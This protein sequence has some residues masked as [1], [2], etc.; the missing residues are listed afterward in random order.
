MMGT[1]FL[2][3]KAIFTALI[4]LPPEAR[5]AYLQAQ[6]DIDDA[7]RRRIEELLAADADVQAVSTRRA[8]GS[9]TAQVRDADWSGRLIGAYRVERT[10]GH[11]GMGSVFLAHR[12]DGSLEQMVAIKVVRPALVSAS[13]LARFRLERQVLALLQHPNVPKMLDAGELPG[14]QPYVV[15]EY[16]AGE[17]ID[18]YAR[19]QRLDVR[20]RLSLFLAVCDAVGYA[21]RNLV[22]HRDL[23]PA[24]VLVDASGRPQLLDFGIAKPLQRQFGAVDAIETGLVDRF[25]SPVYAA[26]EQLRGT[27][28]TT[29]CDVYALG[30]LLYELLAGAPPFAQDGISPG[31]LEQR[32]LDVDPP[33]PSVRA[34]QQDERATGLVVDRDLD[35]IVLR[36]L[37]KEPADRYGSVDALAEDLQRY[38][39]GLPVQARQGNGWYR[40]SRFV[41]RHRVALAAAVLVA[42]TATVGGMLLWRQQHATQTE[43]LR[44]DNMAGLITNALASL[45]PASRATRDMSAREMFERI[46]VQTETDPSLD[47]TSRSRVLGVVAGILLKLGQIPSANRILEQ[48]DASRLDTGTRNDIANLRVHAFVAQSRFDDARRLVEN[49][50]ATVSADD[51]E[52]KAELMLLSAMVDFRQGRRIPLVWDK[53]AAV[54]VDRLSPDEIDQWRSLRAS[55][56]FHLD[57][58][59]DAI[60]EA[61]LLIE[62]QRKRLGPDSPAVFESLRRRAMLENLRG[63]FA[64]SARISEELLQH[65]EKYYGRNSSHYARALNGAALA[66]GGSGDRAQAVNYLHQALAIAVDQHGA[67]SEE[68]W[69]HHVNLGSQYEDDNK[70]DEA[71]THYEKAHEIAQR[72]WLPDDTNLLLSRTAY[73]TLLALE[74]KSTELEPVVQAARRDIAAHPQLDAP[75]FI[76]LLEAGYAL[77]AFRR[78]RSAAKRQS[79]IDALSKADAVCLENPDVKKAYL[80]IQ[81]KARGLLELG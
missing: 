44:A 34:R 80:K 43:R 55:A 70:P 63:N 7:T 53:L 56:L 62:E 73:A 50:M 9:D 15:M 27:A 14:G 4:E 45:D 26:P 77:D 41:V 33:P 66:A 18:R 13:T 32:I 51:L 3:I 65:S 21:H 67:N 39:Q 75:D 49:E 69:I 57:R 74:E 46:A 23:K 35:S 47:A 59:D 29:A 28:I 36:C 58:H 64:E 1:S 81:A 76:A 78:D 61:T 6:Q 11:G 25:L 68:A 24:N 17:P 60:A 20:Q 72:L 16:I 5:S 22:V 79:L 8:T 37:R 31:A 19:K 30:I 38:L 40:L 10:L 54:A 2:R 42:T 71:L 48:V 12:V 52:R